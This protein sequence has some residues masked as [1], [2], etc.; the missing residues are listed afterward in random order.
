EDEDDND[1]GDSGNPPGVPSEVIPNTPTPTSPGNSLI[2]NEDGTYTELDE[3]GIPLGVWELD[4]DGEWEFLPEDI[5]LG[6]LE[7]PD[8]GSVM[9]LTGLIAA[10]ILCAA[11]VAVGRG[12]KE[13]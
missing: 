1:N 2:P 5:P 4:E 3:D 9:I 7:L 12:R 13:E 10:G 11:G 6:L 8:T